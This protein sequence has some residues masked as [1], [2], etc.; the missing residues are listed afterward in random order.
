MLSSGDASGD[1]DV[2]GDGLGDGLGDGSGDGLGEG[3]LFPFD[4]LFF[5]GGVFPVGGLFIVGTF[6]LDVVGTRSH[7]KGTSHGGAVV[8]VVGAGTRSHGSGAVG[9]A[10]V[11]SQGNGSRF[12]PSDA[13][14]E[15]VVETE[16]SHEPVVETQSEAVSRSGNSDRIRRSRCR[17]KSTQASDGHAE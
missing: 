14:H 10:D 9:G 2:S 7:G 13:C 11:V 3:L 8:V 6:S 1:V 15:L 12:F 16:S 5:F 4:A 17:T